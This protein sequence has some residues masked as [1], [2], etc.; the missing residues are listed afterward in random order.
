MS[1]TAVRPRPATKITTEQDGRVLTVRFD[2]PPRNLLDAALVDELYE[3]V[4]RLE[5][6]RSVGAVVLTGAPGGAFV[7]HADG[8]EI[9]AHARAGGVCPSYRQARMLLGVVGALCAVPAAR[10]GLARTPLAGMLALQRADALFL[11]MNRSDKVF[12]AAINGMALGGGCVL[13]LACDIRI[14]A[15]GEHAIG[16][17]E[18]NLGLI[19]AAGGTQRLTRTIGAGRALEL[20]LEGRALTPHEARAA[21]LVHRVVEPEDLLEEAGDVA[22]RMARRSPRVIRELKRAVYDAGARPLR[23][24]I[25]MEQASMVSTVSEP[26]AMRALETYIEEIGPPQDASDADI[27]AA[28]ERLHRGGVVDFGD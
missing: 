20:V 10:R 28:W 23:S 16:L 13:A 17:I 25:R 8:A 4:R 18:S 6:D 2:D 9:L 19:A 5:R 21:G 24:G 11:R 15:D 27:L 26:S 14:A 1:V 3:L 12:V 7:T 22:A